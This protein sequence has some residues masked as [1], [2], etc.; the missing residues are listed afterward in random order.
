MPAD[1]RC[2]SPKGWTLFQCPHGSRVWL[3]RRCR[4]CPGCGQSRRNRLIVRLLAGTSTAQTVTLL[5]L[6]SVPSSDW[7]LIMREW[8]HMVRW[9]RRASPS[10]TY[11]AIKEA[12]TRSGMKHL[13]VLI[14]NLDY[15]PQARISAEWARLTGAP[16]VDVRRVAGD[17]AAAYVAKY[18]SKGPA[19]CLKSVTFGRDWPK[20]EP[21]P[22]TARAIDSIGPWG[23]QKFTA[24]TSQYGLVA[25]LAPD[26]TC[27]GDVNPNCLEAHLWLKSIQDHSPPGS[28]AV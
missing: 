12:G 15:V 8:S 5:T 27:W 7:P 3:P 24:V 25:N 21:L 10:I 19:S 28:R 13:H 14:L 26:C 1:T 17:H 4:H 6:T 11:A 16:I 9:L 20:P 18:V 22:R 23:P 2:S